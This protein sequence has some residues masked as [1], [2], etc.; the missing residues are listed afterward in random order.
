MKRST[1][2]ATVLLT[3]NLSAACL[4]LSGCAEGRTVSSGFPETFAGS[5][6]LVIEDPATEEADAWFQLP[7]AEFSAEDTAYTLVERLKG[8]GKVCCEGSESAYGF[9]LTAIGWVEEGEEVMALRADDAAHTFIAL[10][11]SVEADFGGMPMTYGSLT[12][13]TSAVGISSMHLQDGAVI[14]ITEGSY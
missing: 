4:A 1:R 12:L 2:I 14:Y 11:T 8:Q 5:V 7:Y 6:T 9:F 3:A 13:E 10:Y